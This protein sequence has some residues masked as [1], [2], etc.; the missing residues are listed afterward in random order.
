MKPQ[1]FFRDSADILP[2]FGDFFDDFI[3]TGWSKKL[4]FNN[5]LPPVN[6]KETEKDFIVELAAP[7]FEKKD[8]DINLQDGMLTI[9]SEKKIENK[10]EK[11]N[12]F[13]SEFNY[14]SFVRTFTVP[15]N[16]DEKMIE[17]KFENGLL[18]LLL[19]KTAVQKVEEAHKIMIS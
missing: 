5:H 17:A 4:N 15:E 16:V 7:G 18:T 11:E 3:P 1:K 14:N 2:V 6:I 12:Y 8:L 13:R 10:E 9:K 19:P